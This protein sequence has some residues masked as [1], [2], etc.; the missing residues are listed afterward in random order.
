M[1][2]PDEISAWMQQHYIV[3]TVLTMVVMCIFA[4]GPKPGSYPWE[5]G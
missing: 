3:S 4:F 5:G 1:P 2:S